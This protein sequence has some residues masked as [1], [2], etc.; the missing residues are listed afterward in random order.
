MLADPGEGEL[1]GRAAFLR[2]ET[3]H[4]GDER[5]VVLDRLVL[6]AGEEGDDAVFLEISSFLES[7]GEE[8]W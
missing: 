6:E 5:E 7:T 2:S 1:G 3:F 8:L 4:L